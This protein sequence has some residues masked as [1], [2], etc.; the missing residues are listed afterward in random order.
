MAG[1]GLDV[2]PEEPLLR[3][4]AQVFR[5][6]QEVEVPRLQA[7]LAGHALLHLP[8]VVVTPHIAYVTEEALKRILQTTLGNIEAFA[9]PYGRPRK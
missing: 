8:N 5:A 4:E 6:G 2:L 1:A 9:G 3:D 7:L